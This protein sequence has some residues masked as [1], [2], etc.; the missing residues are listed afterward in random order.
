VIFAGLDV[1]ARTA[2]AVILGGDG[3]LASEIRP[4]TDAV[5]RVARMMLKSGLKNAGVSRRKL[6]AV[7]ATGYGRKAVKAAGMEFPSSMCMAK[8]VHHLAPEVR[9]VID[10]G[11]LVTLAV[12]IKDRGAVGDYL[13]NERCASGSGRFLEM[14]AE[15]LE[16]SVEQIGPLSLNSSRP[17]H[18]TSQCVVFAESEVISHV[19]A[20]GKTEDIMAGLHASIADRVASIAKRLDFAPPVAVTGGVAKN[21]GFIHFLEKSL[22]QPL[23]KLP[24]DPQII[25]A[26]GA[27]L[28][29][30]E[31]K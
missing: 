1:G 26:L 20:G 6:A 18:L 17:L 3:I 25:G 27:A 9:T 28:I 24:Q 12:L 22:G 19:N 10:V 30:R 7:A 29:A 2:K 4:V 13:E 23:H 15:A 11:G 16:L 31:N 21:R 8:A 5:D 14:I